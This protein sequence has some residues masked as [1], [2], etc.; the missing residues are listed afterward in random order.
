MKTAFTALTLIVAAGTASAHEGHIAPVAGHAHG[1]ILAVI[2][3]A[4][5]A[6]GLYIAGRRA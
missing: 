4:A 6:L 2:I 3:A 1:E 5:V